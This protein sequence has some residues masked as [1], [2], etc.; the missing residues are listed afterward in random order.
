MVDF[1]VEL[2]PSEELNQ[3]QDLVLGVEGSSQAHILLQ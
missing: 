1:N 3:P 2:T